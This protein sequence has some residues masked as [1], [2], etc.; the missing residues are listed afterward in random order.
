[1]IDPL[2]VTE[3]CDESRVDPAI[4][5]SIEILKARLRIFQFR[6][7]EQSRQASVVAVRRFTLHE[8]SHSIFERE[9]GTGGQIYLFL[10]HAAMPSSFMAS[11]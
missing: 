7:G 10:E 3:R 8:Q 2:P 1:M 6:L 5:T 11:S 4:V 9:R